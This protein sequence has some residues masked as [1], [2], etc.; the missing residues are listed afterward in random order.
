MLA[1]PLTDHSVN[2]NPVNAIVR[3]S[4]FNPEGSYLASR[5]KLM[6]ILH[7]DFSECIEC[8]ELLCQVGYYVRLVGDQ[9]NVEAF[10]TKF[11]QEDHSY[12]FLDPYSET[13]GS[14]TGSVLVGGARDD[15]N[16]VFRFLQA[17]AHI[18]REEGNLQEEGTASMELGEQLTLGARVEGWVLYAHLRWPY[19]N[20]D[21]GRRI[22]GFVDSM[23]HYAGGDEIDAH[24]PLY[25]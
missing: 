10:R 15:A 18:V 9:A 7:R 3:P 12:V 13:E 11:V 16:F 5:D 17:W 19:D 24:V 22:E 20:C 23:R 25:L 8:W 6:H 2:P 14:R 4:C 21:L 1:V